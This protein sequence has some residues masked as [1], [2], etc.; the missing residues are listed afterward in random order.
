[1]KNNANIMEKSSVTVDRKRPSSRRSKVKGTLH[2]LAVTGLVALG[3]TGCD[4][5]TYT[6][7]GFIASAAGGKAKATFG[8]NFEALDR[9]G[10]GQVDQVIAPVANPENPEEIW[11]YLV[12]WTGKG[13]FNFNDSGAG[14]NFHFDMNETLAFDANGEVESDVSWTGDLR[15]DAFD[16]GFLSESDLIL[17]SM[18]FSGPYTSKAGNGHV[19]VVLTAKGDSFGSAE[20]TIEVTLTGGPYDGYHNSGT[21]QGGNFQWHP[22]KSK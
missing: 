8:F 13:Q 16:D 14:V 3:L 7:G 22:A 4:P 5:G 21:I 15:D 17:T 20:D 10:D 2:S 11:Y 6:G 1:M 18:L 19:S 12:W 9:D